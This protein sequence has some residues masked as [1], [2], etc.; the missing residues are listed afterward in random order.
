DR[1]TMEQVRRLSAR[2][3]LLLLS[4]PAFAG[5]RPLFELWQATR[6]ELTE[7]VQSIMR[8]SSVFQR[9][10]VVRN[11]A[12]GAR[13]IAQHFGAGIKVM[14]PCESLL[15]IDRDFH[16]LHPDRDYVAWVAEAYAETLWRRRP[17]LESIR[18]LI[19]MGASGTLVGRYDR[20]IMPWRS[21]SGD[22]FATALSIQRTAPVLSSIPDQ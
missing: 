22:W 1:G 12:G 16:E 3:S 10:V 6:G 9:M 20:L 8:A 19:R 21:G 7:D 17:H 13:L 4:T 2:R 15:T 11:P 5:A 18:A 14:R